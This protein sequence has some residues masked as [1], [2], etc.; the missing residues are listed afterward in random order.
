MRL[1]ALSPSE[2]L[3]VAPVVLALVAILLTR[4]RARRRRSYLRVRA[5]PYRGDDATLD[6]VVSVFEALHKRLQRRWWRR[7]LW[8]QPSVGLEVHCDR[9]AWLG[10]TFPAGL[11]ALVESALRGAYPSARLSAA[12][13][14]PASP[15]CVLRLKK[16]VPFTR[17][18][19]R[20]DRFEHER[21]PTINRLITAMA[22]CGEPAFV[23]LALTPTPALFE[24]YAKLAYKHHENQL[25]R[26][27]K[28]TLPPLDPSLVER[29]ELIGGLDVQHHPLFFADVR[30]VASTRTVCERIASELRAG[31]AENRLVERGTALRHGRLG[32]YTR[33]VL[34]GEGNPLPSMRKGVLSAVE[35]ASVWHMPS[36]DYLTVPFARSPVPIA[37]APPAIMRCERGGGT[38]RDALGA[39]S[40]HPAMRR[41]NTAAPGTVEQGKSSYLVATVAEDLRRER[42]AVIL[43]DPK[44]DAADAAVS[45][46]PAERTCTL[47]DFA[48]PTCG[49]DPLSV[50]APA[51]T[52]ADYV[53]GA[54][55]N[56]FDQGD[57]KASSD[58]YLRNAIIA[59]LAY[60]RASTLWDAARLL[61]VGEDGYAYRA[62]VAARLRTQ[63]ELKEISEFFAG[64]LTAQ[65]ADARGTTT[66][67]LDA[68]V[69]K[70]ARLLNSPSIKRVLLNDSLR[71]DFDKVIDGA[72]VLVVKGALG[73]M[74]AG[75]TSVLM[76][77]LVG[78]LDA[79]LARRQ[80]AVAE[81]E[82]TAVALKVDEA[83][84]VLNRGFAETM[85]L[86]RS[87]GLET[88]AC[89]QADSQWIDRDVRA[90]LD[91]LFAHRVYFA[92][93]SVED[94]RD[95][96]SLLMAS[97]SDIVRPDIRNLSELGRPDA[98]LHLPRHHA[99]ASWVTPEGR[100]SPFVAQ[101]LPL[102][103]DR[104]RLADHARRQAQR[105]GRYLEDL[106]QPHWERPRPERGSQSSRSD[107]PPSEPDR[108][109]PGLDA[110]APEPD[111]APPARSNRPATRSERPPKPDEAYRELVDLSSAHGVRWAKPV[112]SPRPLDPEPLDLEI[113]ELL[114]SMRHLLSSQIHRRFNPDRAATT[115]QR[116]LKRLAD[117]GLVARFQFHRRDGGGTPMC[118]SITAAGRE[119]CVEHGALEAAEVDRQER[120]SEQFARSADGR[121]RPAEQR[122]LGQACH[123]VRAAGWALALELA[124]AAGRMALIGPDRSPITPHSRP[125]PDGRRMLA[126]S[127]LVLPGGRTP[128]DFLRTVEEGR[129]V[130]VERLQSV[131]PD[132]TLVDGDRRELLIE[133]DDR[134]PVGVQAANKLERYDHFLSGWSAQMR[135]YA[136]IPAPLVVFVC[137]DRPRARE[138]ARA[139]DRVLTAARAY[140]G[141]Y[142]ASWEY[143]ARERILFVAERDVYQGLLSGWRPPALPPDVRAESGDPSAREPLLRSGEVAFQRTSDSRHQ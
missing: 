49:F 141:E 43:L 132:V 104:S 34:R 73:T 70:L 101:T 29:E 56:L 116:R 48:H 37:P 114:D 88:V 41:Q 8:G 108:P 33:R 71:V 5:V 111:G 102:H 84:L 18:T 15:P 94:S 17:R 77:L 27:R 117:A 119:L 96:A 115:T 100:Q 135:R 107:R 40:I 64:E 13:R 21:T 42:C 9:E 35:L 136:S 55:K 68:P 10:L 45:I 80:D 59:V 76:Q 105:G 67:K 25:S 82:R 109:P 31:G 20:F 50:D 14:A 83:P 81:S 63:P 72:E 106:S 58:R 120:G 131:R 30:I 19:K 126:L 47:L 118:Y 6:Q 12:P 3:L 44:G 99:I 140:A 138:C 36:I 129:R 93:A 103:V 28:L 52:I 85:A 74:G 53:V 69:N 121:A 123:D 62:R 127:D 46:V 51:D 61:S 11:E 142:P 1:L 38:L 26:R 66:A 139:A 24:S 133:L 92:T 65:L 86:K 54:L 113:L 39:V 112:I 2:P 128:H 137:R 23:Q 87:A 22:A 124:L 91:A 78:M 97:F 32:L 57:I 125:T 143:P 90:Q 134:L 110:L 60:D 79:A 16:H 122:L 4:L 75:N 130:E 98:R 7:L 89:W 95:A